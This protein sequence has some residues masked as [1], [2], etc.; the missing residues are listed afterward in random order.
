M[1]VGESHYTTDAVAVGTGSL[2]FTAEVVRWFVH[3]RR[4]NRFFANFTKAALGAFRQED[5]EAFWDSVIFYNYV[6]VLVDGRSHAKGGMNR[7]PTDAMFKAGAAPFREVLSRYEPQAVIVCG[8]TL[9]SWLAPNLDGFEGPARD[10]VFYDDGRSVFTRM[11]HP[12]YRKF[13]PAYWMPRIRTLV[14][15]SAA[16]RERGSKIAWQQELGLSNW[17]RP[18]AK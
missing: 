5:V 11:H 12:S 7:R 14:E 4:Y 1:V 18:P 2:G 9:W 15:M 6:P 13:D 3:G 16:P 17:I 8:L 10:V